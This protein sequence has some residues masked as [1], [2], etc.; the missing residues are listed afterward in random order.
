MRVLVTGAT[1]FV[2]RHLVPVLETRG[3]V[4]TIAL[5]RPGSGAQLPTNPP[6]SG[7]RVVVVG[8]I[9]EHTDWRDAL[10]GVDVVV[11]LAARAHVPDDEAANEDAFTKVNVNGTSRLVSE[12]IGADVGRFVLMSSVGAVTTS[13]E[14]RVTLQTP[15]AP[16]TAYGRSKLA[17][18]H[19]LIEQASR[20]RMEWTIL[21]PTLVYGPGNPGNMERLVALIRRGWPLP[22]GAIRNRRSFTFVENL[23]DVT[24][25]VLSHPRAKNAVFFVADGEDLSTPELI[26]K[27]ATLAGSRTILLPIPRALLH[28]LLRRADARTALQRLESSLYV[29][30]EPLRSKVDWTPSFGVDEGLRCM[31]TRP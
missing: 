15:C 5:H 31:L 20:S 25:V 23:A 24:E 6:T 28:G 17:A 13:S 21:R 18:E 26:R 12:A 4:L 3:H 2:G 9:A 19:E 10:D 7:R 16:D 22:F 29:D 8:D 27:I 1:G 14:A 11:H 30:I